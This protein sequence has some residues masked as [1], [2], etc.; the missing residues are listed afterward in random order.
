MV[1]SKI[2]WDSTS[3]ETYKVYDAEVV[4]KEGEYVQVKMKAEYYGNLI[5]KIFTL[6]GNS[7]LLEIRFALTMRNP[8]MN[9]LGPQ[10]ILEIGKTHGPEDKFIIPEPDGVHEYRMRTDRYFSGHFL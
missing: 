9:M 4:K 8:E 7:P 1:V 6:Y 2:S 5:E 3:I 10:P